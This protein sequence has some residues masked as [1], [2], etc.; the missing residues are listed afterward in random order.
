[1]VD[2]S[3]SRSLLAPDSLASLASTAVGVV[4]TGTGASQ[5]KEA[6]AVVLMSRKVGFLGCWTLGS[7]P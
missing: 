2:D 6:A 4:D 5:P 3:G 7:F 1:M